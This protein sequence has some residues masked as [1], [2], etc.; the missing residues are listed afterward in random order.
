MARRA[1]DVPGSGAASGAAPASASKRH[2][3][4][5]WLKGTAKVDP[6]T[7]L[8]EPADPEWA[9]RIGN[10]C[11]APPYVRGRLDRE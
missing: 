4:F 8:T 9:G 11:P 3:L 2:P 5:G 1:E 6:G 7:N 10:E